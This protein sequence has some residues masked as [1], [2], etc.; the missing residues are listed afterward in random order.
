[1]IIKRD[2]QVGHKVL[3]FN[4]RLRLFP[5][6]LRYRWSGPYEITQIFP[7]GAIKITH[8]SN[9]AFQVNGQQ[10]KSYFEGRLV[11]EII[12]FNDPS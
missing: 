1:M 12:Y 5:E 8:P 9:K 7:S 11:N 4:S 6:K 2:F 3:L 10:L